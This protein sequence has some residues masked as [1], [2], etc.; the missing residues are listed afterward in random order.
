MSA[1]NRKLSH[2]VSFILAEGWKEEESVCLNTEEMLANFKQLNDSHITE[3]IIV[4]SADVKALCP[5]LDI[6]F[7]VEKVCEVVHSSGVQVFELNAEELGLYLVLSK[8]EAEF[9]DVGLLQFFPQRRTKRGWTRTITG[10]A[11]DD[12]KNNRF[13]P[14]LPNAEEPDDNATRNL[15]RL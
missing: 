6:C 9:R 2:L 1:Y 5:W 14:W 4:G 13:K 7:T 10:C 11:L 8:T 15:L 12:N 3:D